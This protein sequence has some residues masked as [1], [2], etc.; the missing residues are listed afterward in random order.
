[1]KKNFI[2]KILTVLALSICML[3]L[4]ACNGSGEDKTRFDVELTCGYGNSVEMGSYAPFYVEITNNG[5]D[6]EGSVQMIVPGKE[7]NILYEKEL[8]L[9]AG[10]TKTVELTGMIQYVVR[11]VNIRVADNRGNVIW[12]SLE[13]CT[14]AAD[15]RNVNIGILSDDYSALGYMDR[16]TFMNNTELT[17]KIYELTKD[18]FPTDWRGL[19]MLDVIVISDFSTDALSEQQLNALGLWV[20]EGGLL[21]V[22]TGST[23]NKTLASLN[24]KLFDAEVGNLA[25]YETMFGLLVADFTYDYGY[26]DTYNS[27]YSDSLYTEFYEENYDDLRD[28][29][30]EQYMDQFKEEYYYDDSYDTWDQ[31]WEDSFYWYCYDVFYKVYLESLDTGW[32]DNTE[33]FEELSF[34]KADVLELS[35]DFLTNPGTV[36]FEGET[37]DA[38]TYDLAY[39]MQQ[40]KGYIMLCGIDFTKTPFSNYDGNSM[41]FVHWVESLIG[42]KCHEDAMNYSQYTDTY[43]NPYDVSYDEEEILLGATTATV[44]PVLVYIVLLFLYVISILVVYLILRHKKKTVKL[45]VIYPLMAAG[46]SIFIF[47]V[48]FSTRIYRPVI[49]ATTLIT[50]NGNTTIQKTYVA[51]TVPRNKSYEVGFSPSQSAEYVNVDYDSYYGEREIDWD[52]YEVGYKYG[53]ESIDVVLGEQ[54]AMGTVNF[55]LNSVASEQRKITVTSSYN[56]ASN[57]NITNEYGCDLTNA[58]V[59]LDGKVYIIGDIENGETVSGSTFRKENELTLYR[60][61][62]GEIILQDESNKE[63]W[64]LI[65]GSLSGRYDD[66]L[67]KLRALNSLTDY[68]DRSDAPD[69]IFVAIPTEDTAMQLQGDTNYTERRVEIVYV[70]Y[71]FPAIGW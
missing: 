35:G 24:G 12:S 57:L 34:V 47:C 42:A 39:A 11:Q 65:L 8:S 63:L 17:T 38:S 68:V 6:F 48:G 16:Q 33:V 64:G 56:S 3:G 49:G 46:L 41:I 52:S 4:F 44:P 10:G 9:Q 20:S 13:N 60:D 2:R 26:D 55:I 40:G 18:T 22:G 59:I 62:L 53:Y 69:V 7:D 66:Y 25:R 23:S 54:E 15:L 43:Y 27:Y 5:K 67:C 28:W 29:L 58:A 70:E 21:M 51:L 14:I 19:D 45:W 50:P 31:Y 71:N 61:G 30:E 1:M 36:L 32:S 37:Q